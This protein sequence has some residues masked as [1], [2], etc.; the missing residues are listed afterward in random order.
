MAEIFAAD[1]GGMRGEG[2]DEHARV[3]PIR[4]RGRTPDEWMN[5]FHTMFGFAAHEFWTPTERYM[6]QREGDLNLVADG[7]QQMGDGMFSGAS[8][9]ECSDAEGSL[10]IRSSRPDGT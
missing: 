3:Q 4:D 7:H 2:A 5:E 9:F 8:Y 6:T 10:D 1:T